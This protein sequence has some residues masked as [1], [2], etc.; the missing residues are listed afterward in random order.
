MTGF[1]HNSARSE[2]VERNYMFKNANEI[3]MNEL[4]Y[5]KCLNRGTDSLSDA[6]LLA[7]IMRTGTT[8]RTAVELAQALLA[9]K[10]GGLLN[11]YRM[12]IEDLC[13]ISG[14]GKVKAIQLKCIGEISKRIAMAQHLGGVHMESAKAVAVYYMEQLRYKEQE[15]LMVCMFDSKCRLIG[16]ATISIG[17]VNASLMSPRDIFIRALEKHAVYIILLHNHPS[18][19][20]EPS[21]ADRLATEQIQL[22]GR[23]IGIILSDH[24]IIGDNRYYS[25]REHGIIQAEG[26]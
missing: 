24:I 1:L 6:E 11:L 15:C 12:K 14:I 5:E 2:R 4:P 20:P 10:P 13:Q 17:T 21:E 23:M 19:V 3:P 22:C 26:R 8:G 7:V 25:F 9:K 16:D 18:G